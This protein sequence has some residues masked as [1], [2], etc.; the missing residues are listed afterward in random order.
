MI[1]L[2]NDVV[3]KWLNYMIVV[4]IFNNSLEIMNC[5]FLTICVEKMY[6]LKF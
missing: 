2:H 1:N 5:V 3:L 6:W 4:I